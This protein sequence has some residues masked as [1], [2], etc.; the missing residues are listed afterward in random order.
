MHFEIQVFVKSN[1]LKKLMESDKKKNKINNNFTVFMSRRQ[2]P[3]KKVMSDFP[4]KIVG[5]PP[6][7]PFFLWQKF[8]FSNFPKKCRFFFSMKLT[9]KNFENFLQSLKKKFDIFSENSK[10]KIFATKKKGSQGRGKSQQFFQENPTWSFVGF[11]RFSFRHNVFLPIWFHKKL[12]FKVHPL[13]LQ[14]LLK[15][16]P[17][18]FFSKIGKGGVPLVNRDD[19][20]GEIKILSSQ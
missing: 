7:T 3:T 20:Q 5:I 11:W 14:P 15:G 9:V 16:Y 2:N 18:Y 8:L 12:N 10:T 6:V 13:Y 1:W 4:E 17:S 19:W